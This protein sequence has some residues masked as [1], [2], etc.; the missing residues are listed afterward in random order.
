MIKGVVYHKE[1]E[2]YYTEVVGLVPSLTA[3]GYFIFP[4]LP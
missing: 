1:N 3:R 2:D 4:P